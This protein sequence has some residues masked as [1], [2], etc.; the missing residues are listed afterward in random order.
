MSEQLF[1]LKETKNCRKYTKKIYE[2]S[3]LI[4]DSFL[5]HF[6]LLGKPQIIDFKSYSP[7][8]LN[9]FK[10]RN[11]EMGLEASGTV[12]G[13]VVMV[14]YEKN[15]DENSELFESELMEWFKF[16]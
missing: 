5:S 1:Q 15:V 7:Q 12:D 9:M 4:D 8:S 6:S 14:T 2:L 10:I 11:Y 3:E 13:Y 16:R